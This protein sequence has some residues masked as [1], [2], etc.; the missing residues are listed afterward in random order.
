MLKEAALFERST[1]L[2]LGYYHTEGKK[3]LLKYEKVANL[4]KQFRLTCM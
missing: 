2:I 3:D 1:F 4:I